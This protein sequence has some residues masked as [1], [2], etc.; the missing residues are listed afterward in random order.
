MEA[1]LQML[2]PAVSL[3]I[4]IFWYRRQGGALRRY[5]RTRRFG[6]LFD[7]A[8]VIWVQRVFNSRLVHLVTLS[9]AVAAMAANAALFILSITIAYWQAMLHHGVATVCGGLACA[10]MVQR[11]KGNSDA[12]AAAMTPERS[13]DP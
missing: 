10:A 11:R 5:A 2:I 6:W 1:G 7:R 12:P 9:S 4:A 8:A 13:N 3:A